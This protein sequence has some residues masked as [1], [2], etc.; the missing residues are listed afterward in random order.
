MGEKTFRSCPDAEILTRFSD[1]LSPQE[2]CP[3]R[4]LTLSYY[5]YCFNAV[6]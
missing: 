5:R 3:V 2:N 6:Y 1:Q 4:R